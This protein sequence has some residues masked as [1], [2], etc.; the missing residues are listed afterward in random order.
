LPKPIPA[1]K[2]RKLGR[3]KTGRKR[4]VCR[5]TQPE[6]DRLNTLRRKKSRG[7]YLGSLIMAQPLNPFDK[8]KL[9]AKPGQ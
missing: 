8:F 9:L 4:T 2:G 1:K 7:V 3:P 5:F 6:I